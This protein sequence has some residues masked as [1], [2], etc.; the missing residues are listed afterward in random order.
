MT[1]GI[2]VPGWVVVAVF[3]A[4][5]IVVTTWRLIAWARREFVPRVEAG[6]CDIETCAKR[7]V[8]AAEFTRELEW[9]EKRRHEVA[10]AVQNILLREREADA[11]AA[12][13]EASFERLDERI[14]GFGEKLDAALAAFRGG[15]SQQ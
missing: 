1:Q 5:A 9:V 14:K 11:R 13:L 12:R 6:D 3:A 15:S 7:F 8:A 10:Q 2:D 4:A